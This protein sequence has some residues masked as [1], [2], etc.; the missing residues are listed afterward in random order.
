MTKVEEIYVKTPV[1]VPT[2]WTAA[3]FQPIIKAPTVAAAYDQMRRLKPGLLVKLGRR[4]FVNAQAFT[5]WL[6]A[7]G[8][9]R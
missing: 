5:A 6:N 3:E 8:D 1:D 9:A 2:L 4:V 7:G